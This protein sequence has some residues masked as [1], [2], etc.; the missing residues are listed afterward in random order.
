MNSKKNP[1]WNSE[2][3]TKLFFINCYET[4]QSTSTEL[5]MFS[6]KNCLL[7]FSP[8]R[9]RGGFELYRFLVTGLFAQRFCLS[10][11][12]Q[13][14]T[15]TFRILKF[16]KQ[17]GN[18][19]KVPTER[20][21]STWKF[22]WF[23]IYGLCQMVKYKGSVLLKRGKSGP[24]Y[25]HLWHSPWILKVPQIQLNKY[26]TAPNFNQLSQNMTSDCWYVFT[27]FCT[28]RS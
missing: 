9:R 18:L 5:C 15:L 13:Q 16:S 12:S 11:H 23:Q 22:W 10:L 24:V 7:R 17:I 1:F 21:R 26:E 2:A 28:M 19:T 27:S 14:G 3:V 4:P 8:K 20:N 6:V 25:H